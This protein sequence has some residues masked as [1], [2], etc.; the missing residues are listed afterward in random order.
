MEARRVLGFDE[1]HVEAG[2]ALI[3]ERGG[4]LRVARSCRPGGGDVVD[5]LD[6]RIER[7]VGECLVPFLD[8]LGPV[9]QLLLGNLVAGLA[10]VV[11]VEQRAANV[12]VAD[13]HRAYPLVGH[14]AIGAGDPR[15]GVRALR[16]QLELGVLGLEHRPAGVGVHPVAESDLVVV[17]QGVVDTEA[18]GP[19]IG[20]AFLVPV[21]VVLDV[22]LGADVRAHLLPRR[23]VVDVVV[24]H[25]LPGLERSNAL[26][27]GGTRDPQLHRLGIVAVDASDRSGDVADRVVIAHLV[28]HLEAGNDV[29]APDLLHGHVGGRV[30]VQAGARLLGH[31]LPLREDLVLEHVGVAAFLTIV[32]R[33]GVACPHPPQLGDQVQLLPRRDGTRVVAVELAGHGLASPE[34][35]ALH[36]HGRE[37][38]VVLEREVLAPKGRVLG[39]VCQLDH[40][41]EGVAGLLLSLHDVQQQGDD[42]DGDQGGDDGHAGQGQA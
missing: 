26:D 5:E 20:Q 30:A 22:A 4:E 21:E 1:I 10:G 31:V 39:V 6:E 35:R 40:P 12:V 37:I 25:A 7:P 8:P 29:A 19:G 15:L 2:L 36:V 41:K 13:L 23:H 34:P 27:E 33:E 24:G 9:Q 17:G 11:D 42:P 18:P 3:V 14:V 38:G 32:H 16:P 28:E